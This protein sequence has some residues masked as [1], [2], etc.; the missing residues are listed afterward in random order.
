MEP[1]ILA[2]AVYQYEFPEKL[3]ASI[4]EMTS[5]FSKSDWEKSGIAH[6]HDTEQ[7]IRTSQ[8]LNFGERLPFWDE[9]VRKH[10]TA[11]VNHYTEIHKEVVT[12]DEGFNL[13]RYGVSNKYDFH[14]D[15]SWASYRN[16]S[17]LIYLNPSEYE[18]GETFFKHFDIKVK[19]EKPAIVLF[20]SN[21]AYLHAALPV[22]SGEKYVLVTWM[23]DLPQGMGP[24][25][26]YDMCRIMGKM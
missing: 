13:L 26:L 9:E 12:K 21:Y 24:S 7:E 17:A 6:G 8:T 22:I 10:F 16:V 19:P 14:A 11:S 4:V 20:P 5:Q 25:T 15:S 23:N 2:P 18:G 1:T 3:A